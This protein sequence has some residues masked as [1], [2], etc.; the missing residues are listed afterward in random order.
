MS[1]YLNGN[2]TGVVVLNELPF[3][4]MVSNP[5]HEYLGS[6]SCGTLD[7]HV[8]PSIPTVFQLM[9]LIAYR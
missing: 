6:V 2:L 7:M 4:Q 1:L 9:E 3:K 5:S 8:D